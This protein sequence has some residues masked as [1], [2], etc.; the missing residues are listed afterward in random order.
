MI[1]MALAAILMCV[2]LA[3]CDEDDDDSRETP[4]NTTNNGG[5]GNNDSNGGNGGNS[6]KR[7]AK[8][9]R[10]DLEDGNKELDESVEFVYGVKGNV[11]KIVYGWLGD[12][13][14][15]EST[16]ECIWNSSNSFTLDYGDD[17]EFVKF[18]LNNGRVAKE[19]WY[20]KDDEEIGR[21]HV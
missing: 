7:L 12:Y 13:G 15:K 11:V 19:I 5:N 10:Y 14:W 3:S 20:D 16:D 21:A 8:V 9:M 18:V 6:E 4:T 1:G 17:D 2:N